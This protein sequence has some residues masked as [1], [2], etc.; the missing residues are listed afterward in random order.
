MITQNVKMQP[1]RQFEGN[2]GSATI[3]GKHSGNGFDLLINNNLNTSKEAFATKE[4]KVVKTNSDIRKVSTKSDDERIAKQA[5]CLEN[6]E[7]VRTVDQSENRDEVIKSD[8]IKSSNPDE[9]TTPKELIEQIAGMLESLRQAVMQV[10]NLSSQDL[11]QLMMEQG[12][13]ITDLLEPTNLQQLVISNSGETNLLAVLTDENLSGKMEQLLTMLEDIKAEAQLPFTM[14]QLKEILAQDQELGRAAAD[15]QG[16]DQHKVSNLAEDQ[17]ENTMSLT[18]KDDS[19][20]LV[21]E[22]PKNGNVENS[23]IAETSTTEDTANGQANGE[24]SKEFNG[25]NHFQNFVDNLVKGSQDTQVD[26]VNY[27]T[28]INDLREIANQIID[29]IKVTVRQDQTSMELQL[30]PENLGRVN[31]SVQSKNG[32]MTAQFIVQSEVSKEAIESQMHTLRETLNQQGI[33]VEAI[34]VTVSTYGFDQNNG[35]TANQQMQEQKQHSG[36]RLTLDE[37]MNM[38]DVIDIDDTNEDVTGMKGSQIDYTA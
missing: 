15:S 23:L 21:K 16:S 3:K 36:K 18:N 13:E 6:N 34:E 5:G 12:L 35:E 2:A 30:N 10:L 20:E 24:E 19:P 28:P 26:G 7:T 9:N 22:Y 8:V 4:A 33:K 11:D 38:T 14:E 37:A 31:L 27:P 25:T 17:L 29:R 1:T 32:V